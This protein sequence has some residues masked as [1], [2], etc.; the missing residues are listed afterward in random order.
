MVDKFMGINEITNV[1]YISKEEKNVQN[2]QIKVSITTGEIVFCV[3]I[4]NVGNAY[5]VYNVM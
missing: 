2:T 3:R 5:N 1:V 4:F